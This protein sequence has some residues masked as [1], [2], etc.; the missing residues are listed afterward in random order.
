MAG[1]SLATILDAGDVVR[2]SCSAEATMFCDTVL[3]R[4]VMKE[5]LDKAADGRGGGIG[6]EKM[7]YTV[8]GESLVREAVYPCVGFLPYLHSY[9]GGGGVDRAGR[10]NFPWFSQAFVSSPRLR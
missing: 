8:I 1:G 3:T 7:V 5:N 10:I 2:S 6:E 4:L 9:P